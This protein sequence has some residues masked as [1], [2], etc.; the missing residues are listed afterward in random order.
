M[1]VIVFPTDS[2]PVLTSKRGRVFWGLDPLASVGREGARSEWVLAGATGLFAL[3][4]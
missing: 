1:Y 4:E 3:P 2:P